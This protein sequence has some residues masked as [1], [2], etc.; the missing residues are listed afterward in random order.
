MYSIKNISNTY[1]LA[2]LYS[3]KMGFDEAINRFVLSKTI[4]EEIYSRFVDV[5]PNID[6]RIGVV[7]ELLKRGVSPEDVSE[8]ISW[9]D[10]ESL[11]GRYFEGHGY[12]VITG[13]YIKKPRRQIDI[14]AY[15][16]NVV[17]CIDCKSWDK[18]I[19][20]SSIRKIVSRQ[21]DR[22]C[23]LKRET[24]FRDYNV[25]SLIIM[26]RRFKQFFYN[27]IGIIPIN[28]LRSFIEELDYYVVDGSLKNLSCQDLV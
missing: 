25:Y 6:F 2:L 22:C 15:K 11:V 26:M 18:V 19:T 21:V 17:L 9:R 4:F 27:G 7:E 16:S 10:F 5:L 28:V 23:Y 1:L 13:Y 12:T 24:L 3:Y 20:P 14:V 8:V